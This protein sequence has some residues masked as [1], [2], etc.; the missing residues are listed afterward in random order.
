MWP[1]DFAFIHNP[2]SSGW[3]L[4]QENAELRNKVSSLQRDLAGAHTRRPRA[5]EFVYVFCAK[6]NTYR[7]SGTKEACEELGKLLKVKHPDTFLNQR[8]LEQRIDALEA[9]GHFPTHRPP[10]FE[11]D[12][13]LE[14]PTG[15]QYLYGRESAVKALKSLIDGLTSKLS[16]ARAALN[17]K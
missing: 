1:Y 15:R 11:A 17:G 5:E 13:I 6:Y 4:A 9:A 3:A 8:T 2:Y 7:V 12:Y 14:T 16:L 10:T